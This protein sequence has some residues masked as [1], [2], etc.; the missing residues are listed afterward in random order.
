MSSHHADLSNARRLAVARPQLRW[1]TVHVDR[2]PLSSAKIVSVYQL[3]DASL[4][5]DPECT[6]EELGNGLD[7]DRH[8]WDVQRKTGDVHG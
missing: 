7:L 1:R 3:S 8:D 4:W 6:T 2:P 5:E